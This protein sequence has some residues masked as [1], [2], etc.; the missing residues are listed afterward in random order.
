MKRIASYLKTLVSRIPMPLWLLGICILAYGLLVPWLGFYLD[1]WYIV[2]YQKYIG[3]NDF[4]QFFAQDRPFFGYV[5][6]IFVPIFKD[7]KIGWQ[8]FAVFS[9]A[10]AACCFWWLLIKLMPNRRALTTAA[11]L[12]FTVYPGFQMHWFS[13][14]YS[15]VFVL[16]AVYFLSFILM[17]ESVSKKNGKVLYI[18]G[19]VICLIIGIVPQETFFGIE[20]VRPFILWAVIWQEEQN[21]KKCLRRT[22][23]YW[24]PYLAV[25][26]GFVI[27]RLGNSHIYSYQPGLLE[28]LSRK[29][30]DT[31][32]R[33]VSDVFWASL[34]ALFRTWLKLIE[35]LKQDLLTTVSIGMLI[36]I[37]VGI[38]ISW[39][40]VQK[41]T[42]E[43]PDNH[44]NGWIILLSLLVTITAMAPFLMGAF[45][46]SLEFPY[47]RYLIAL[48]PGASLFLAAFIDTLLRTELHKK[49]VSVI[50]V[51]FAVG[52][53]FLAARS[54]LNNWNAQQD[55]F[56]QLYWRA[57]GIAPNTML[58]TEDVPFSQYYTGA[59]L[60][61]P[62]NLIYAPDND[63]HSIPYIFVLA[64]TQPDVVKV[65]Q[66]GLPVEFSFRSF[67]F[68]GDTSSM[69]VF[70]KPAEGC[71]RI[72]TPGDDA[73]E[74][75]RVD[76][77]GF[78]ISAVPLSNIDR[79]VTEPENPVVPT[80]KFFGKESHDQWCYYFEKA[81]LARQ[82]ADYEETIKLYKEAEQ[83]GFMPGVYSEW[84][85][86]LDAYVQ[87]N[88]FD[89]AS[90]VMK[91]IDTSD[92][93]ETIGLCHF[94]NTVSQDEKKATL[95]DSALNGLH[96]TE[97]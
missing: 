43:K 14:M 57:P 97:E 1:D 50:L 31:I 6:Q 52:A 63:S 53:Q 94:W 22:I 3:A 95:A 83:A 39:L 47:N 64:D 8:I 51:G 87:T 4:S 75:E 18:I 78:W 81:D 68:E 20:F 30:V 55:F 79:I 34:D 44:K 17:I 29:P 88:Q 60:T 80:E 33:L 15:Q 28:E 2:L 82:K 90:A 25:V 7:S 49:I 42:D 58:I 73:M 74:F 41:D 77:S 37:L 54:F 86:L 16:M 56:W 12:F 67:S 71:L 26:A 11:A 32:F 23:I 85:P 91:S 5:Y 10:L 65:Y 72:L 70:K 84:I 36:V 61:A 24:L 9:H 21:R 76:Q 13:V 62:L 38:L 19:A 93:L 48:A 45:K 40:V 27:F 66:S 69:L 35:L 92:P 46:I 96:C 59:S 89:E